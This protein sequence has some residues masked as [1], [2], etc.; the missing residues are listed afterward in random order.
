MWLWVMVNPSVAFFKIMTSR[1]KETLH[2]LVDKWA[3][4]LVSDGYAVYLDWLNEQQA[5]LGHLIRRAKGVSQRGDRDLVWFGERVLSELQRLIAWAHTLPTKGE[6][7][8]WY[9][10]LTHLLAQYRDRKGDAGKFAR[11]LEKLM[12]HLWLFLIEDRVEPTNNRAERAL[13]F[14]VIW[15]RMMQGTS[16]EKGDRWVERILSIKQTCRLRGISTF[17]VLV[18]AIACHFYGQQPDRSWIDQS[19]QHQAV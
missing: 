6:A 12:D 17:A 8:M 10:R 14:A 15:R 3:G 16:G 1:S 9:A 13:G 5:W 11:H 2:A 4:L 7:S 18:D 19:G